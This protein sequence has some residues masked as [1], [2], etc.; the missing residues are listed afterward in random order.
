LDSI[1]RDRYVLQIYSNVAAD[2][3]AALAAVETAP[4]V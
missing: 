3:F 1:L 2:E 4:G